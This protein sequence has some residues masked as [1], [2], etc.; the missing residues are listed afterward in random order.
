MSAADV[1]LSLATAADC[2]EVAAELQPPP[3]LMWCAR[4]NGQ[5]ACVLGVRPITTGSALR[6]PECMAWLRPGPA[7]ARY[8]LT[9]WRESKRVLAALRSS[10]SVIHTLSPASDLRALAWLER[11]GFTLGAPRPGPDGVRVHHTHIGA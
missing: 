1:T 4:I 7:V 10:F 11:L 6:A 8:P 5:L 2:A 9:F 3:A